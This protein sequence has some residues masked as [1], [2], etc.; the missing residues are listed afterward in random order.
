MVAMPIN[1]IERFQS[2]VEKHASRL[3]VDT[4]ERSLTYSELH[5]WSDTMAARVLSETQNATCCSDTVMLLLEQSAEMVAAIVGVLKSGKA[6]LPLDS[7]YPVERLRTI[8]DASKSK[9]LLTNTENL[10]CAEAVMSLT[11]GVTVVNLDELANNVAFVS[12]MAISPEQLAY[13]MYT[14]GST[15]RPKGVT[16]D[17]R[18]ILHFVRSYSNLLK[19][20]SSDRIALVTSYAHTV[21]AID[22]FSA[23]LN[24]ATILPYD[25]S[26]KGDLIAFAAW[27]REMEVS[28]LHTVP[29]LFRYVVDAMPQDRALEAVRL[30]ILGGEEVT[31]QD[32]ERYQRHFSDDCVLVNLFGS[33]EMFIASA[34]LMDKASEA[35]KNT[36]PIGYPLDGVEMIIL[37]EASEPVGAFGVGEITYRSEYVTP[38]YW[39]DEAE[40]AK[41]YVAD[42]IGRTGFVFRSGDRGRI[43]PD[44]CIEYLGRQ[45]HQVKLRGN[46]IELRE[47][48]QALGK[49]P[50]IDS[51]V[52]TVSHNHM[53]ENELSAFYVLVDGDVNSNQD[54]LSTW[55]GE[56]LPDYMIP[57]HFVKLAELP[58]TPNGKI[59]RNAL[60]PSDERLGAA[61]YEA[62]RDETEERLA[63]IW[64]EV[65][66]IKHVGVK[67]NFFRLG[68]HSLAAMNVTNRTYDVFEIE[69]T[70]ED[71]FDHQNV[72]ELAMVVKQKQQE[73]ASIDDILTDIESD[74]L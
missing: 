11:E 56:C 45:D 62:P 19:I 43:L 31:R 65:L 44:G 49:H 5:S 67:D 60:S 14:S 59:D 27:L 73:M 61:P 38:G 72:A 48:E 17:H 58:L 57:T 18:N 64:Q 9:L 36:M 6:Y 2:Q 37:D 50:E 39:A 47:V 15:G 29:S 21:S 41:H 26:A 23:L 12:R 25:V 74:V 71:I 28:V 35:T 33:S 20:T 54:D 68:G 10:A 42:P 7:S 30:V 24:G 52:V 3:A 4:A 55:L 51:C 1:I 34:F 70:L 22:I 46:R 69:L 53:D 13:V 63:E 66:E 40:L 8:S 32:F 16:Q